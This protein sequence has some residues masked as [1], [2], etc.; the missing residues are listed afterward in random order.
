MALA[1]P[2]VLLEMQRMDRSVAMF[3]IG[4][5]FGGGIGFTIAAGN[6]ITLDGHD[7]ASRTHH[8]NSGTDHEMATHDHGVAVSIKPGMPEPEL[9]ITALPDPMSGWN[10]KIVTRNFRFAPENA[11]R[12]HVSGE[13]HAHIYVN[14]EKVARHYG[15]WFHIADLAPGKNTI[16]VTL[17]TNDHRQL[18]VDGEVLSASTVIEV[19]NN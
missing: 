2:G 19:D 18:V 16:T 17:N 7:H 9:I 10:L 8:G 6:G 13:G 12:S 5:V 14:D 1:N 4:L 3:C 15:H 11:S